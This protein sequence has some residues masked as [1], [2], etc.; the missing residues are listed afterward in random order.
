MQQGMIRQRHSEL[1]ERGLEDK[2]ADT[3][4]KFVLVNSPSVCHLGKLAQGKCEETVLVPRQL[5]RK[6]I[7]TLLSPER[8]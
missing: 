4:Q 2:A 5:K 1:E 7:H 3:F 8:T 6:A